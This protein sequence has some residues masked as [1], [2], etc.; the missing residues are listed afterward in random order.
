MK[1]LVVFL[2][3]LTIGN[4]VARELPVPPIPP[5]HP[6]RADGAPV[7]N[8]DAQAPLQITK[9]ETSVNVK[10]YRARLFD[11]SMGFAP[12]SKYQANEDRK[13]IQTPGI[14]ITVPLK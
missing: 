1:S 7:P 5:D 10:L 14:S 2:S 12:G 3:F 8:I 11:P 4:A 13:P 6:P 9:E